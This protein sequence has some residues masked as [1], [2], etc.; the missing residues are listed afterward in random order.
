MFSVLTRNQVFELC[1]IQLFRKR[2]AGYRLKYDLPIQDGRSWHR[3]SSAVYNGL[4]GQRAPSAAFY[5][6]P[7]HL[8]RC[9]CTDAS[10]QL[11]N[12]LAMKPV[13]SRKRFIRQDLNVERQSSTCPGLW[14][15]CVFILRI[16][17]SVK[18]RIIRRLHVMYLCSVTGC[19]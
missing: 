8:H 6:R 16:D 3:V 19:R 9:V 15:I 1:V 17:F 4:P 5:Q 13:M 10:L 18:S 11:C 2:K 12:T 7:P 14:F